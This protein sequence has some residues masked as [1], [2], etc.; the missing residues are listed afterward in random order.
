MTVAKMIDFMLHNR[1][2]PAEDIVV[3]ITHIATRTSSDIFVNDDPYIA[4]VLRYIHERIATRLSRGMNC[5]PRSLYRAGF[6]NQD[7]GK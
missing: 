5:R 4:R 7:S 2:C 1:S 3:P 6:L